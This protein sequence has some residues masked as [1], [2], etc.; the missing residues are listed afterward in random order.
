MTVRQDM[1]QRIK[2]FKEKGNFILATL[3]ENAMKSM[4][5]ET[6]DR[7]LEDDNSL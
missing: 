7:E 4:P 6:L 1:E 2:E 3:T 5:A